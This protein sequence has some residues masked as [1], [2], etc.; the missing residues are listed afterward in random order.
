M[1]VVTGAFVDKNSMMELPFRLTTAPEILVCKEREVSLTPAVDMWSVGHILF[2]LFMGK[3]LSNID[4]EFS[5]EGIVSAN[6]EVNYE[7]YEKKVDE[8]LS[9]NMKHGSLSVTFSTNSPVVSLIKGLLQF[10]PVQNTAGKRLTADQ[11]MQHEWFKGL[12]EK[13][14]SRRKVLEKTENAV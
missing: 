12:R 2:S 5:A 8:F 6:G 3:T 13:F 1:A 14:S 9:G 10:D 4:S 11:A 7:R